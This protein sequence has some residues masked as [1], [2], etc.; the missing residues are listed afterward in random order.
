[1]N[2]PQLILSGR[3]TVRL[4]VVIV[5]LLSALGCQ[6]ESPP[7]PPSGERAYQDV[8]TQTDMGPRTPG[9]E[10]HAQIRTWL[11]QELT[12]AGWQVEEQ[13]LPAQRQTAYNIVASRES[14]TA[15][16]A[17][18]IVI[19]AHYD[20]RFW[21]DNDPDAARHRDPVPGGNDG[22]SGVAVLLEL[23]R[24]L[25]EDLPNNVWLVF[26]DAEDNGGIPGWDWIMGSRAFVES[27]GSDLP[28]AAII[29]D[30]I[31][32]RD[33]N[34]HYEKSSDPRLM[35]QIWGTAAELGYEEQFIPE[36]RFRILDDHVPFLDAGVPA[37]DL[38]D[39]DYPYWHTL[40]DTADKV[41]AESLLAVSD[42]LWHWLQ[43]RLDFSE[44]GES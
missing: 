30:M 10:A 15:G 16:P 11:N 23:A 43:Q 2:K 32:D 17:P 31:G 42:T 4:A 20:S 40:E 18:W 34:I 21:A 28:D 25:P 35:Q 3:K 29:V 27:L 6:P 41:S 39:F 37:A 9:S 36:Y 33:L 7:E 14:P 13:E 24:T 12:E 1:M 44:P 5:L 26:F 19:G 38:I 8:V 22:A